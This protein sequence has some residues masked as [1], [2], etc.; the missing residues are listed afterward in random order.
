M[1]TIPLTQGLEAVVD[2]EDRA[3]LMQH[4]WCANKIGHTYYAIRGVR[5]NGRSR[6]ILMHRV[7]VMAAVGMDVDHRDGNG[8]N[9]LRANLRVTTRQGNCR[10]KQRKPSGCTS[11]YKGVCWDAARG[12]WYARIR[13][14]ERCADGRSRAIYLGRFD[15]EKDAARA[16]DA[17]AT[18]AFGEFAALN[19]S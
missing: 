15:V 10:N 7:I 9:N 2:D 16:Y 4:K 5:E 12:K 1:A 17:A 19:F 18:A 11:R 3:A 13:S 6:T 14:G 8:L